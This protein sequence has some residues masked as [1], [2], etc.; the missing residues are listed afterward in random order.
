[1]ADKLSGGGKYNIR[2]EIDEMRKI[3]NFAPLD[4]AVKL[5]SNLLGSE[6]MIFKNIHYIHALA[7]FLQARKIDIADPKKIS[8]S[9]LTE[10]RA[11][12]YNEA[13]K[14]TFND[15]NAI[16]K[17]LNNAANKNP[18]LNVF[19][20][21]N[22]PFK[23][24]P[25]NILKRGIEYSPIGFM[26]TAV[27]LISDVK[28]GTVKPAEIVDGFASAVTG[29]GLMLLGMF[30]SN[31]GAAQGSGGGDDKESWFRRLCGEQE[32]SIKLGNVSYTFDWM[33]PVSIPFFIGVE[34]AGA[35]AQDDNTS[36]LGRISNVGA[37]A[38]E[39]IL[40]LSMLSGIQN[41][42]SSVK[43]ANGSEQVAA[44]MGS[45]VGGYASQM[46]PTVGGKLARTIDGTRRKNYIDK[47]SPVPEFAQSLWN[48][49]LSKIPFASSARP[50]YID[51]WGEEE[52][53]ENAALRAASNFLS[54]GY[55][56]RETNDSINKELLRIKK[57]T[58]ENRVLID[59]AKTHF[60]VNG[61][62]KYL[63][64]Q[65]YR[66]Y[67]Q[68]RGRLA[69]KYVEE[70]INGS[71]YK[72]LTDE[73]RADVIG[74]IYSYSNAVAKTKVS[75]YDITKSYKKAAEYDEIGELVTYYISLAVDDKETRQQI[76]QYLNENNY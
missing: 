16:A 3:F 54:P 63:S 76:R 66:K 5:N 56:S 26:T 49:A 10:A 65:E 15:A 40:E 12:A 69:R 11:Y 55:A 17:I 33:A 44:L 50:A 2:S 61:T 28:T 58:G 47:T 74:S 30:L 43:N 37:N 60:A 20:E 19:I 21:S 72:D 7:S 59:V 41:T 75:D 31:I 68:T 53:D 70:F 51:P 48:T 24:T 18:I 42:I 29:T 45:A 8:D 35:L 52:K 32:Y 4:N 57:Q 39:P 67:A 25:I 34:L 73:E 13:L 23:K 9:V 22:L 71:S 38:L 62:E 64:A 14:A 27:K 36:I 1:M 6:D 46:L